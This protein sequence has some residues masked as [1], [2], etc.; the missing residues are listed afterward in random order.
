MTIIKKGRYNNMIP[1]E[2]KVLSFMDDI[3]KRNDLDRERD[4]LRNSLDVKLRLL[5]KCKQDAK[6]QCI[7]K[8]FSKIYNDAT[9]LND[10]YKVAYK[11][12]LDNGFRSFIGSKSDKGMDYYIR[13]AIRR[14]PF[15]RRVVEA[16]D[17]MI[18]DE[19]KDKEINID[20]IDPEDLVFKTSDD[21][22]RKLDI[23]NRDLSG[24]DISEQIRNQ[25]KQTALSEIRRAKEEK[26]GLKR[27]EDELAKDP[28][29]N[30]Q[31]ALE[32]ALE[33]R[34][35]RDKKFYTPS[36]FEG[37]M[38]NKYNNIIK[39]IENGNYIDTPLYGAMESFKE[40]TINESVIDTIKSKYGSL[41]KKINAVKERLK[42]KLLSLKKESTELE[43]IESSFDFDKYTEELGQLEKKACDIVYKGYNKFLEECKKR[44]V[45]PYSNEF[46]KYDDLV[47]I[48]EDIIDQ[49][50]EISDK[51]SE[52]NDKYSN[53]MHDLR[54]ET[55][56]MLYSEESIMNHAF[57]EAV[58]EYTAL[59]MLKALKLESF[60]YKD[61]QNIADEYAHNI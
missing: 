60:T 55:I 48:E 15:A 35:I 56:N 18:E 17:N 47:K 41:L 40:L 46:R 23:I 37:V 12:D 36:L 30:S 33:F 9:P 44:G 27:M 16:V 11:D 5:D 54:Y 1:S 53:D 13:E 52:I 43:Y 26:E 28:S 29:I 42:K 21:T 49:L 32:S 7:D 39:D 22:T 59:S 19:Y 58:K 6:D 8:I 25:V 50:N 10:E 3:D 20:N 24:D 2:G 61:I 45:D 51:I 31:D 34:G 38:I 4:E 14:S 57:I